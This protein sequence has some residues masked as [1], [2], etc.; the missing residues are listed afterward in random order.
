MSSLR[1]RVQLIGH[2]G[3][4]PE[5]KA[6]ENGSKLGRL[7]IA[8]NESYKNNKGEWV[9][10][11]Q[12]HNVTLWD[13]MAERAQQQLAKGSFILLEG[14]LVNRS[15]TDNTGVKKYTIEI[16]ATNFMALDKKQQAPDNA[17]TAPEEEEHMDLP[18]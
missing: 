4:D 16:R 9:E 6:L 11:T 13:Q 2:L 10:E 8:T 5:L 1:N 17:A 18:F 3:A 15:Y 7:R 14:K 12:W